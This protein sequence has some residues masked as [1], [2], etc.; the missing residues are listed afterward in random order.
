MAYMVTEIAS[1]RLFMNPFKDISK[2]YIDLKNAS[3]EDDFY[4][5]NL[6]LEISKN[7]QILDRIDFEIFEFS[8]KDS[9]SKLLKSLD[10]TFLDALSKN[11]KNKDILFE[12]INNDTETS[13]E[14]PSKNIH[15]LI[16]YIITRI[17]LLENYQGISQLKGIKNINSR[18]LLSRIKNSILLINKILKQSR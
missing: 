16:Y 13:E 12:S 1:I 5:I 3:I 15:E 18:L 9:M 11:F 2:E 8:N 14:P 6:S 7:I 17:Y 10:F 4:K